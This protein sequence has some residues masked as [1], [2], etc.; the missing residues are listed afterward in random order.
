MLATE[1]P[2]TNADFAPV[3]PERRTWGTWN[4]AAPWTSM[5]ACI[6]TYL[7]ASSPIEGGMD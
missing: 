3:P 5:A 7:L 1:S 6:P 4:F 2:L